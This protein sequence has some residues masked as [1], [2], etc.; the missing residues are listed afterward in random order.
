MNRYF[1]K[2]IALMISAIIIAGT[3]PAPSFASSSPHVTISVSPR[4]LS[5]EGN[6]T[7]SITLKNTNA[8]SVEP[9]ATPPAT[10][11]PTVTPQPTNP[12]QPTTPPTTPPTAGP[13]APPAATDTPAPTAAPTETS[14]PTAAPTDTP[15]PTEAPTP[16]PTE[17]TGSVNLGFVSTGSQFASQDR[18]HRFLATPGRNGAYTNITI[19]NPYGVAFSTFGVTVPAGTQKTFTGAMHVT[20]DMLGQDLTFTVSWND[21]GET[22]SETATC[23]VSRR[24]ASVYLLV[25]R[26]ADPVNATEGTPVTFKYTF[27]NTGSVPLVNI[28]LVDK[29][30]S[31]SSAPMYSIAS[32][33]PGA[34]KDW[35]YVFTMGKNTILSS[36]VVTFYSQGSNVPLVNN[37]SSMTIGLI[38]SQ[39]SK[40]IVQADPSPNGVGFTLYLVNNGNQKLSSLTVTDELGNPVSTE[41]F[42]L[43]VGETKVLEYFVPNP[44]SVRYVVF[45]IVGEDFNGNEFKDNTKSFIVRPYIDSSLLG[46]SFTAVTTSSLSEENVLGISFFIENTGS[47]DFYNLVVTEQAI[48]YD[49]Q[50]WETLPVGASDKVD[51]DINIG[52]A[53]NLVFHLTVEDSS[54]NTY[55]HEAY[56]TAESI[57]VGQIIPHNDPSDKEGDVDVENGSGFG[58]KLDGIITTTGQKLIRWFRVL[59]LIAA[60]TALIMLALGVT[61]LVIKRNKRDM[62]S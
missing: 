19:S 60:A 15:E 22:K 24:S 47:L 4:E 5:E 29:H 61:E 36:P 55:V 7:V 59:G 18:V 25:S 39:I 49:L 20:S 28:T 14:A 27:T 53:R 12:A 44:E 51:L 35:E 52:A 33:A 9:T 48:D 10:Q 38:Q 13:T 43:A 46:L 30:V 56:V 37:V 34:S 40:D 62:N 16:E 57:D 8:A 17:D 1:K 26:T 50:K 6:V 42:S 31:G 3:F 58:K 23:R 54:G 21:N 41:P 32:L 11:V 2:I 45:N